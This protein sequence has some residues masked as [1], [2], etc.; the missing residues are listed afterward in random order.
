MLEWL[1]WWVLAHG[2][3]GRGHAVAKSRL[4]SRLLRCHVWSEAFKASISQAA[5]GISSLCVS[6]LEVSYMANF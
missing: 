6:S 3:S 4:S 5:L 2:L 1:S